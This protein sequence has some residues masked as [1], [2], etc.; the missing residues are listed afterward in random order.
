[1]FFK[2]QRGT[3]LFYGVLSLFSIFRENTR[4]WEAWEIKTSALKPAPGRNG[5]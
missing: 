4:R 3:L 5:D 2:E 1:M